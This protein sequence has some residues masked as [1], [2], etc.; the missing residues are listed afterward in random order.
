MQPQQNPP[1]PDPSKSAGSSWERKAAPEV[2][3]VATPWNHRVKPAAIPMA[4]GLLARRHEMDIG[5]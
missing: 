1:A 5:H 2:S 4:A 3:H